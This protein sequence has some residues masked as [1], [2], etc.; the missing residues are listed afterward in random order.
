[1][2]KP[3]ILGRFGRDIAL[4]VGDALLLKGFT[5]LSKA[6]KNLPKRQG[7]T[8][9][10]SVREA[11]FEIGIAEAKEISFKGN[12]DLAPEEYLDVIKMKAAI[13]DITARI[14]AVI[15]GGSSDE[16]EALGKYG[17]TLG[18][19]ATMRDDYI[20]IF[21]PDE[22]KNRAENECLPLPVLYAFRDKKVKN[23]IVSILE[24]RE[25]TEDDAHK[26]VE[27]IMETES[28]QAFKKEIHV[29]LENGIEL[30]KIIRNRQTT[31]NLEEMLHAT[32]E[33]L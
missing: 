8:I 27:T 19:L 11:F 5:L 24:K 18:M 32:V 7:E 6:C 21:E 33:G 12:W 30:L 13:A 2:S 22:I 15:G 1:G 23:R 26:I 9:I 25:L 4:L 17:R 3:T 31:Q 14:G 29:L 20:D 28:M 10:N 16:I